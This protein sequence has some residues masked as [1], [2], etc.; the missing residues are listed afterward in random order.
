MYV[1]KYIYTIIKKY[2]TNRKIHFF[3][4]K[5]TEPTGRREYSN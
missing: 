5:L 2:F 3:N 4:R 1:F